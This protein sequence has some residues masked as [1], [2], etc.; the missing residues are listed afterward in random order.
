MF[1]D[2]PLVL[3]LSLGALHQSQVKSSPDIVPYEPATDSE[4]NPTLLQRRTPWSRSLE[5]TEFTWPVR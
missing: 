5:H 3:L 1:L 2:Y 4:V